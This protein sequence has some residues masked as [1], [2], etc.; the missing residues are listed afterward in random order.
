MKMRRRVWAIG[1]GAV[2]ACL[3]LV[4]SGIWYYKLSKLNTQ[5]VEYDYNAETK[6]A[7]YAV[8]AGRPS[9]WISI[10]ELDKKAYGAIIVS[11]DWRFFQHPGIDMA[12]IRNAFLSSVKKGERLRGASTITQQVVKNIY[13]S[14]KRSWT[15]KLKEAFLALIMERALGKQRIL[16]IYLNVI[17]YGEGVYGIANASLHYFQRW[18]ENLTPREGAFLA[19]LLPSPKKYSQSFREKEL[20]KFI[21]ESIH[22]VLGKMKVAKFL[23]EEEYEA[24]TKN[25]FSWENRSFTLDDPQYFDLNQ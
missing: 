16:E 10:E 2:L 8:V 12:Q 17:E 5:Y 1:G 4:Y 25:F 11:E 21:T 20:S 22:A 7:R 9:H 14:H 19:V 23:T 13:L 18:P 24:A 15:R 3:L 6:R